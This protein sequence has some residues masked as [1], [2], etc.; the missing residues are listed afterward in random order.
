[1]MTP[2]STA[3]TRQWIQASK[4]SIFIRV[5][6]PLYSICQEERNQDIEELI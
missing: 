3:P 5:H 4:V 1:M 6:H 2:Q